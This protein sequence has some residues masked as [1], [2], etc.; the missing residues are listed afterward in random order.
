MFFRYTKSGLRIPVDLDGC[1]EGTCFIAGGA[2][3]L[4]KE[5]NLKMLYQP[6]MNVLALNN[7]AMTLEN[8]V[9]F[10][11]GGDKPVCYSPRIL[12]DPKILKFAIISRKLE[13]VN[14]VEWY[15]LPSTFF[16]GTHDQFNTRNFLRFDRDFVWWKNTFYIA[17]QLAY[18]LGFRTVYLIGCGFHKKDKTDYSYNTKLDKA[19]KDW[20]ERVYSKTVEGMKNL[21]PA[22]EKAGLQIISAT[23]DSE[24]NGIYPYVSFDDAIEDAMLDFPMDYEI[25]KCVHSSVLKSD[26][27]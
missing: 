1:W 24:L 23:K 8:K 4:A 17:V 27:K 12:M 11:L 6:G 21:K 26:K 22:I 16:F 2:P 20:N 18:R 7:T 3:S 19:Q 5:K 14:G 13:K 9:T 10:W 25:E 15:K